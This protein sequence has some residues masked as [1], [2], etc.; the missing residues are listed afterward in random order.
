VTSG[1]RHLGEEKNLPAGETLENNQFMKYYKD[2][3]N[4]EFKL[5]FSV[6]DFDPYN[7][8]SKL[9]VASND[10]PD[11]LLIYKEDIF[12]LAQRSGLLEDLSGWYQNY[13]SPY[14][15]QFYDTAPN[16]RSLKAGTL[17]GKL[18]AL[19]NNL[20][21]IDSYTFLWVRQDWL[22]KLGLQQP[23]TLDDVIAVAKAFRD[24]DPGGNG[25]G[26]TIGLG[27][28]PDLYAVGS[29]MLMF[30]PIF[31]LYNAYPKEWI[32]D[33]SGNVV[34]GSIQ[35]QMKDGLA[36][37]RQ[38]YADKIIDPEFAVRK[39]YT[40]VLSSNKNGLHFSTWWAA[41]WPLDSSY[42]NSGQKADWR[43]L[44][45]P[46][47]AAGK[48]NRSMNEPSDA[49]LVIRKGFSHPEAIIK[50]YNVFTRL[51]NSVDPMSGKFYNGDA[52]LGGTEGNR[53]FGPNLPYLGYADV[54]ERDFAAEK[55]VLD[56]TATVDTLS[57]NQVTNYNNIMK[58]KGGDHTTPMWQ[59]YTSYFLA[60]SQVSS[61]AWNRTYGEFYGI[62]PTMETKWET[63]QKLEQEAMLQIIMGEKDLSYF[64]TFVSQW[65]SLGGDQVTAEVR[66]SLK[67]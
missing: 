31:S 10:L 43:P 35:P 39:D 17:D 14:V 27:G 23:R 55:K 65:K 67:K 61:P 38:M 34:Y 44:M 45:A 41:L 37:L 30:G 33:A 56:G 59:S 2:Q 8:K 62:T 52:A 28:N 53:K 7:E 64:D 40:E 57:G 54:G 24:K 18:Y 66:A 19:T 22:D 13:A 42:E 48:V 11:Y 36:R 21:Q 12:R 6:A 50:A 46:F 58:Y 5:A 25:P 20:P 26:N 32:K 1:T 63:L 49:W 47:N 4:V 29:E 15:K 16:N 51:E 3:L 9:L 60:A